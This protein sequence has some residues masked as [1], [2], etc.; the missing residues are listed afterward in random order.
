MTTDYA[1]RIAAVVGSAPPELVK[2]YE[3][4]PL[5]RFPHLGI[6]CLAF[7]KA[8]HYSKCLAEYVLYSALGVWVLN[9]AND[10][11]PYCLATAGP[12]KGMIIHVFHD[13]DPKITF[14]SL[15]EF[16]A[17]LQALPATGIHIDKIREQ[18]VRHPL[19]PAIEALLDADTD[20]SDELIRLY[21]SVAND[22][23]AE[24]KRRLTERQDFFVREA[25]AMQLK[26]QGTVDDL[27]IANILARD[28]HP[29]V[30][31]TGNA[32]VIA[33]Q[34]RAK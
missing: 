5:P 20:E 26:Q 28:S 34:H 24:T 17:A 32:A 3:N 6:D 33:I 9:D 22:L 21:L 18:S 19:N 12:L 7:D 14:A 13:D 10:S 4:A 8:E 1:A 29:Q 23:T 15:E 2:F 31:E 25:L 27:P 16:L 30:A 11:N